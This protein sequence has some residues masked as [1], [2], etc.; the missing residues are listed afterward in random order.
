MLQRFWH[1]A[2]AT[3]PAPVP[4]GHRKRLK[5]SQ[6]AAVGFARWE[7]GEQPPALPI[8]PRARADVAAFGSS[9]KDGEGASGVCV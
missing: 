5:V 6:E 8:A 3:G 9:L 4:A 2:E 7:P 1:P